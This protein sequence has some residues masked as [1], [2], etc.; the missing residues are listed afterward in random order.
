[1][2][3]LRH[4]CIIFYW[5][6]L[7]HGCRIA[8]V[9]PCEDD[10]ISVTGYI[11]T[12]FNNGHVQVG[13]RSEA[14]CQRACERDSSCVRFLFVTNSQLIGAFDRRCYL[15]NSRNATFQEQPGGT[16]YFRRKCLPHDTCVAMTTTSQYHVVVISILNILFY[17]T[18]VI[19]VHV[20]LQCCSCTY[21]FSND[22]F[23]RD[24]RM[25]RAS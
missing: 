14:D 8:D 17:C 7:T 20:L 2:L 9:G 21:I 25:L 24:S 19:T 13:V 1:M 10:F 23:T 3:V 18:S 4:F 5:L 22:F 12:D 16:L 15:Y 6:T 11:P